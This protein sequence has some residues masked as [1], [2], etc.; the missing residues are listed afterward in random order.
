MVAQNFSSNYRFAGTAM[1]FTQH[2]QSITKELPYLHPGYSNNAVK[3]LAIT[4]HVLHHRIHS[5]T[6]NIF[7]SAFKMISS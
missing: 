3:T 4:K 2:T 7:C 5:H 1:K 6:E